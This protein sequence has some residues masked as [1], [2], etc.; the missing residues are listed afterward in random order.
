MADVVTLLDLPQTSNAFTSQ[1]EKVVQVP[2]DG[3]ASPPRKTARLEGDSDSGSAS[4]SRSRAKERNGNIITLQ[5]VG[6][7]G[8]SFSVINTMT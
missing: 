8:M 6:E 4:R 3:S 7:P 5:I 2:N 1:R